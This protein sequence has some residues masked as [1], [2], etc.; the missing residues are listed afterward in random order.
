MNDYTP[1]IAELR[2][3]A[4]MRMADDILGQAADALEWND[5]NI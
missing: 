5:Q 2:K 4:G 3:R 1:L